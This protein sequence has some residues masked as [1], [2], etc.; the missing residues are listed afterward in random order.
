[1]S[2]LELDYPKLQVQ[3][4]ILFGFE[5]VQEVQW[6]GNDGRYS[7]QTK[8]SLA[9][10][11]YSYLVCDDE[12]KEIPMTTTDILGQEY[13]FYSVRTSPFG[14]GDHA[15]CLICIDSQWYLVQSYL[16]Y[17]TLQHTAIDLEAF[18]RDLQI[19]EDPN[20]DERD[21]YWMKLFGVEETLHRN[22]IFAVKAREIDLNQY[23]SKVAE[24]QQ[25]INEEL[26]NKD[27]YIYEWEYEWMLK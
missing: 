12:F 17:Y 4:G 22:A 6:C 26:S 13:Q 16:E 23:Q 25:K 15:F 20:A 14:D 19:L 27:S 3:Y 24:L 10:D 5:D 8:C 2:L 7:V 21:R 1:M 9:V 18:V 11:L